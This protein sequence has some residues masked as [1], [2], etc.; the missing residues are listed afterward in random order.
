[1]AERIILH[2][3]LAP[4]GPGKGFNRLPIVRVLLTRTVNSRSSPNFNRAP[5]SK[6]KEFYLMYRR[7][8]INIDREEVGF[9]RLI[10][11]DAGEE[12]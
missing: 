4:N 12:M 6:Y 3:F 9:H 10:S 8:I 11:V 2:V 1:M 7:D 5:P